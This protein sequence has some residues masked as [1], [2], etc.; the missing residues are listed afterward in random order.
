MIKP[1]GVNP[2]ELFSCSFSGSTNN[3]TR[4]IT[5][6]SIFI[7]TSNTELVIAEDK[8]E[9]KIEA[10]SIHIVY[11]GEELLMG[12]MSLIWLFFIFFLAVVCLEPVIAWI[13]KDREAWNKEQQKLYQVEEGLIKGK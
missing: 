4:N 9:D 7:D 6:D 11:C 13:K 12:A 5:I 8:V 1:R 2:G 10:K 3:I